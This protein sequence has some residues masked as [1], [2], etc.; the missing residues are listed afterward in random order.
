MKLFSVNPG[1]IID[2]TIGVNISIMIRKKKEN[3]QITFNGIEVTR[4]FEIGSML[5]SSEHARIPLSQSWDKLLANKIKPKVIFLKKDKNEII[6]SLR[7]IYY[8]IVLNFKKSL[9]KII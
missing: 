5:R 8:Y 4:T 9:A 1:A 6:K 3:P 7:L 2:I